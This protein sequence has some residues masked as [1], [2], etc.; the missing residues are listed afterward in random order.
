MAVKSRSLRI[1]QR[2]PPPSS[3]PFSS[4]ASG[5]SL[6]L[7]VRSFLILPRLFP[8][9]LRPAPI[10]RPGMDLEGRPVLPSP[11]DIHLLSP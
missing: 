3:S 9:R 10:H 2:T 5:P 6:K 4:P 7:K 1:T 8:V 11:P